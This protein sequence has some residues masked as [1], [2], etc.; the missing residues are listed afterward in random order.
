MFISIAHNA[1]KVSDMEKALDFYCATVGL[2]KAFELPDKSGNPWIVYLK[3]CDGSFIEL[4]YGGVKDRKQAYADD[5][6]CYRHWSIAVGDIHEF[7]ERAAQ[8]G[9]E[10][11]EATD[12]DGNLSVQLHDP[13]GNALYIVQYLP[14]SIQ[15]KHGSAAYDHSRKGFTG[16]A[17]MAFVV[18]DLEKSLEFYSRQLGIE[19]A[20]SL[21]DEQGKECAAG[22]RVKDGCFVE[23][24][25]GGEKR[26]IT[27]DSSAGFGHICLECDEI[28]STVES[29][30]GKG[31]PI[32]DEVK[33][34]GDKNYQAWTHDPDGNK[35]E[36]M[37]IDPDS[38]QAKA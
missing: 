33:Q 30:R 14:G 35:V 21:F 5:T 9:L 23:L 34:G 8:K 25:A 3:I 19:K 27:R 17:N 36:I 10:L 37:Q 12:N 13:D 4:F 2:K 28:Y 24:R 6:A 31:A 15:M 32:D 20:Y 7:V 1:M 16:I 26:F 11:C 22:L 18:S 29:I 38:P